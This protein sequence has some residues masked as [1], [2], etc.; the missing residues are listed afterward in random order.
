MNICN[1]AL[2]IVIN[3]V[4]IGIRFHAVMV[5]IFQTRNP[6]GKRVPMFSLTY[7]LN[8]LK[9]WYPRAVL[10][11][12]NLLD[13]IIDGHTKFMLGQMKYRECCLS[14]TFRKWPQPICRLR[15]NKNMFYET[16]HW[17]Q[18]P[19]SSSLINLPNMELILTESTIKVHV[20]MNTKSATQN[21]RR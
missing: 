4:R 14:Q 15:D 13:H 21:V 17:I 1:T 3:I 16:T 6:S 7:Y 11:C 20:L 18:T 19:P 8:P 2:L 9:H 10:Q 5:V 12:L